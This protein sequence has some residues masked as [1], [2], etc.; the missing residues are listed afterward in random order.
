MV[1]APAV[2]VGAAR[3]AV[4][5][6]LP[7]AADPLASLAGFAAQR[8]HGVH[9]AV[10]RMRRPTSGYGLGGGVPRYLIG[11]FGEAIVGVAELVSAIDHATPALTSRR[12]GPRP[13]TSGRAAAPN[14]ASGVE[15]CG[16]T[17]GHHFR[18]PTA[19][20]VWGY[21]RGVRH[22]SPHRRGG[23]Q[24]S[25]VNVDSTAG[26]DLDAGCLLCHP[27]SGRRP[28]IETLQGRTLSV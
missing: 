27:G 3:S 10:L 12:V 2:S 23:R 1:S 20:V 25:C 15:V 21:R 22:H 19:W 28:D 18:I 17:S 14:C 9:R 7:N 24:I 13:S 4:E 5:P 6:W 26:R 8:G 11:N 16:G